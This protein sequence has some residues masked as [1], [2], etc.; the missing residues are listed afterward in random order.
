MGCHNSNFQVIVTELEADSG[1]WV[2]CLAQHA[3]DIE[4][5]S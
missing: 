2:I 1:V 3:L 5:Q 4:Q